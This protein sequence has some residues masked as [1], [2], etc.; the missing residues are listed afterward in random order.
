MRAD[1]IEEFIEVQKKVAH[2]YIQVI[3]ASLAHKDVRTDIVKLYAEG[4]HEH[5]IFALKNYFRKNKS[6]L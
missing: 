3:N 6:D 5:I 4:Y 1:N 2:E